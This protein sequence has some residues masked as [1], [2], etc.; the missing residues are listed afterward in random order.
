[1]G[2]WIKGGT[3]THTFLFPLLAGAWFLADEKG[4]SIHRMP[5]SVGRFMVYPDVG[6]IVLLQTQVRNSH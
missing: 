1:M 2:I 3:N 6:R 5:T 4:D